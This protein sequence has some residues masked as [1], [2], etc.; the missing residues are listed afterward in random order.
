[1]IL[2]TVHS[3]SENFR[4]DFNIVKRV[5]IDKVYSNIDLVRLLIVVTQPTGLP[6][7]SMIGMISTAE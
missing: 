3:E 7:V 4:I 6:P 2:A 5:S 1:M